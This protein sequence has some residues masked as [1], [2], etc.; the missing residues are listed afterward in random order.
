MNG[1]ICNVDYKPSLFLNLHSLLHTPAYH[2]LPSAISASLFA[3]L[4][5]PQITFPHYYFDKRASLYNFNKMS[6]KHP[7]HRLVKCFLSN[8]IQFLTLLPLSLHV[9]L[10]LSSLAGNG[11]TGSFVLHGRRAVLSKTG[12]S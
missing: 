9:S 10:S 5:A 3:Q 2:S 8:E 6:A 4:R 12:M 11:N 1:L 7:L